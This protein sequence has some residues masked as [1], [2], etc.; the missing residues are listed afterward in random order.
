MTIFCVEGII[1]PC[2]TVEDA[3]PLCDDPGRLK[4]T[5]TCTLHPNLKSTYNYEYMAQIMQ[6]SIFL[7]HK[8]NNLNK[9]WNFETF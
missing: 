4:K 7:K 2:N 3:Y 1:L 8:Q 5:M 6:T 9:D